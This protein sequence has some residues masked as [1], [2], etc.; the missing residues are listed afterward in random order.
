M[1]T[2]REYQNSIQTFLTMKAGSYGEKWCLKTWAETLPYLNVCHEMGTG[3]NK[4]FLKNL[5]QTL[6]FS[7]LYGAEFLECLNFY[8]I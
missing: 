8:I 6:H 7:Q 4:H 1:M 5:E 3:N 2:G